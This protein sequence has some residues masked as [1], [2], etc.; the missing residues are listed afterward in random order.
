MSL[1]TEAMVPCT[2]LIKTIQSDGYGGSA[3]VWSDGE[4]FEAAIVLDS[5]SQVRQ[6]D[7]AEA[8]SLYTVTISRSRNLMFHDV[9]RR[10][11]DGKIFRVLSKGDDK[12]TPASAGL[13]MRQ[14]S[15]EEWML[16]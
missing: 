2:K 16:P 10:N 3:T 5:T 15:A 14:M 6:G 7:A 1:L 4:P 8:A 11:T 13:D 12:H 9:F